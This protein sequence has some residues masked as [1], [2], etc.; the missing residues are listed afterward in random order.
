MVVALANDAIIA[1]H[2]AQLVYDLRQERS[3]LLSKEEF[4]PRTSIGW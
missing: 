4:R 1:L 3:K 2:N